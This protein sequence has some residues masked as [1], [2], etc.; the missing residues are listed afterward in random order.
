MGF[1]LSA[2]GDAIGEGIKGIG[3]DV[4]NSIEKFN[5][6]Y[7]SRVESRN[8][9]FGDASKFSESNS[10]QKGDWKQTAVDV[11]DVRGIAVVDAAKAGLEVEGV[12]SELVGGDGELDGTTGVEEDGEQVGEKV[13]EQGKEIPNSPEEYHRPYIRKEVKD[14]IFANAPKDKNGMYLDPNTGMQI[15]GNPDIGHKPG[16]EFKREAKRAF[17][18]RLTQVEFN[19]KMNNASYYQLEDLH[20]NRSHQYE[21]KSSV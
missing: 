18:N 7:K 21:D 9:I 16:H 2:I 20:N 8:G 11:S 6:H 1:D 15:E 17:E 5:E 4:Q 19:E 14:E 3:G 12:A 13:T 10:I